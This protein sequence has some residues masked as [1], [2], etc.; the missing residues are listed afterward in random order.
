MKIQVM[1]P[2]CPNCEKLYNLVKEVLAEKGVEADLEKVTDMNKITDA[3]V[4]MTPGLVIDGE[5]KVSGKVPSKEEVG[6][7]IS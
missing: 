1:G 7:L 2:G 3:G 5:V 6:K 4:L